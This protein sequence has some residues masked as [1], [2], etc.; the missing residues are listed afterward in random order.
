[1]YATIPTMKRH[2]AWL[3]ALM[4]GYATP[5]AAAVAADESKLTSV[6]KVKDIEGVRSVFY[7]AATKAYLVVIQTGGQANIGNWSVFY[8]TAKVLHQ[9][10][11][12]SFSGNG[13]DEWSISLRAP[14]VKSGATATFTSSPTSNVVR[15]GIDTGAHD[16]KTIVLSKVGNDEAA[17]LVA[18]ATF[19][20]NAIV[21]SPLVLARDD[22]GVYYYVDQLRED[23][24]GEAYRVFVGRKGAMRLTALVDAAVDKAG[25][26]FAT[27][28]G[29]LRLTVN[30]ETKQQAAT[31]TWTAKNKA[32][33]LHSLEPIDAMYLIYRELGVYGFLG[34]VC[35]DL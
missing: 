17:K 13:T 25:M 6:I 20:S 16:V 21:R 12:F 1:M 31:L 22:S 23:L 8:G 18:N 2:S 35:D 9:Q 19:R 32:I 33:A 26:V 24:G 7:N 10:R 34:T 29:N 4:L 28:S 5:V 3:L 15:C 11:A 30:A 27:K 14:R